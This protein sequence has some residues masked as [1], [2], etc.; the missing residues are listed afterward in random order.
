MPHG[1]YLRII[2]YLYN[3]LQYVWVLVFPNNTIIFKVVTGVMLAKCYRVVS[4]HV[5]V[6]KSAFDIQYIINLT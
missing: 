5:K 4:S 3:T 6:C 1:T 2:F